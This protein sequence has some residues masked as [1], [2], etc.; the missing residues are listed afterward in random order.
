MQKK[1]TAAGTVVLVIIF[2][3]LVVVSDNAVAIVFNG[4]AQSLYAYHGAVHFLFRQTAQLISDG[5]LGDAICFVYG[6]V[7]DHLGQDAAAGH[8]RCTAKGLELDV[9]DPVSY[10]HLTLPTIA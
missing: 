2:L 1:T 8:S 3:K 5:I 4:F 6:F 7:F 9:F 10:T